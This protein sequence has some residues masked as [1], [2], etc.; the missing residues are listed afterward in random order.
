MP[1]V[2]CVERR[3]YDKVVKERDELRHTNIGLKADYENER[4]LAHKYFEQ[5]AAL[6]RDS[7]ITESAYHKVANMLEACDAE[8]EKLRKEKESLSKSLR[9]KRERVFDMTVENE[10]LRLEIDNLTRINSSVCNERDE[11]REQIKS[12]RS[13]LEG[14][15]ETS[16]HYAEQAARYQSE[17]DKAYKDAK[18]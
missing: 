14:A 18:R 10:K 1:C 2:N 15:R 5:A 4:R 12:L 16:K 17:R 8:L 6:Q 13:Q 9:D 11:A 7:D 3:E